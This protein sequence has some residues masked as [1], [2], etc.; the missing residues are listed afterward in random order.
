MPQTQNR[1]APASVFRVGHHAR[2]IFLCV[3]PPPPTPAEPRA[4]GLLSNCPTTELNLQPSQ[5]IC[6]TEILGICTLLPTWCSI[7]VGGQTSA[8]AH[9]LAEL[10]MIFFETKSHVT[11]SAFDPDVTKSDSWCSYRCLPRAGIIDVCHKAWALNSLCRSSVRP[12]IGC[13]LLHLECWDYRHAA[14]C[15]DLCGW[16]P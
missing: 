8:Q 14:S 12:S 7:K 15:P 10:F 16:I 11:Q 9:V 1:D 3:S 2:F 4:L 6:N 13:R 5:L